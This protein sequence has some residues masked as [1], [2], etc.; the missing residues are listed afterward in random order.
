MWFY[1]MG[2]SLT[3]KKQRLRSSKERKALEVSLF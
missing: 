2:F 3:A 1:K